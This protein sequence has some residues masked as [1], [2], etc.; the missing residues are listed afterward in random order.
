MNVTEINAH[1]LASEVSVKANRADIEPYLS[2]AWV[3]FDA[4]AGIVKIKN[5]RNIQGVVHVEK[6]VYDV[7]FD[8]SMEADAMTVTA[9]S[10]ALLT[11]VNRESLT[12]AYYPP[13]KDRIRIVT[14]SGYPPAAEDAADINVIIL[15]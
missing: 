7:I 9:S 5:S 3:N 14:G 6:G 2:K 1:G 13:T 12:G 10:S 15:S 8:N 11:S 4:S